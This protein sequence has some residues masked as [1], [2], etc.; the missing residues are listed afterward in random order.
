MNKCHIIQN[1]YIPR[2]SL[3][4]TQQFDLAYQYQAGKS[5]QQRP[6]YPLNTRFP[7]YGEKYSY[8]PYPPYSGGLSYGNIP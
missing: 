1:F 4:G 7:P 5:G 8:S 2:S 6:M 3:T